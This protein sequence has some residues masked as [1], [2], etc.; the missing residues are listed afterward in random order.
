MLLGQLWVELEKRFGSPA[1]ISNSLLERLKIA[2]R[3]S[4]NQP[5]KLQQFADLCADVESQVEQLPSLACLNFAKEMQPVIKKL[6]KSICAK[7]EKEIGNFS[8]ANGGAYLP[9][10]APMALE[11]STT[12]SHAATRERKSDAGQGAIGTAV[13]LRLVNELK[14]A[15]VSLVYSQA[16]DAPANPTIKPNQQTTPRAM[17]SS[18]CSTSRTKGYERDRHRD[19]PSQLDELIVINA[20][21]SSLD[22]C[23]TLWLTL[24][25]HCTLR[26]LGTA[27]MFINH[28]HVHQPRTRSSTTYTFINH[29]HVH[30]ART[31]ASSTY[32]FINH[33]HVHQPRTCASTT[34]MFIN[35]VH[36]HQARTCSSSTYMFIKHVHVYQA[37]I[38]IPAKIDTV[39]LGGTINVLYVCNGCTNRR[40][41]FEGSL[42]VEDGV[43]HN[44]G[45]F[46]KNGSF[47]VKNYMT[48]GLLWYG[49]K[50]MRGEITEEEEGEELYHGTAKSMEGVL[51]EECYGQ[52]KE[53]GCDIICV[54]QDGDSSSKKSVHNVYGEEPPQRVYKCGGHVGRSHGNNLKDFAKQKAFTSTHIS[55]WKELFPEMENLKCHCTRHSKNCGCFSKQF[56]KNAR[57]NHFCCLQQ[58]DSPEEYA[59]RMRALS[60]HHVVDKHSWEGG[61]CGFHP[62]TVCSCGECKDE[63]ELKCEGI[64]YSTKNKLSCPFHLLAYQLE[65]ELRVADAKSVIH[66]EMGR[67]HSNQCEAHF[68]VLPHFRAKDQSLNR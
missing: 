57:V 16:R 67:G 38:L 40:L 10:E 61:N 25:V 28:V 44:R 66:P 46:S 2:A 30:Q 58:C 1:I 48:Q 4:E 36:V 65:C 49:N 63:F 60:Q 8:D 53:E 35:H 55:K 62:E 17:W 54:W 14:K 18:P 23:S 68:N 21:K 42:A 9:F 47:I 50:S 64:P 15:S 33:V 45:H 39:G 6:P 20:V 24:R 26:C 32:M 27:Y 59:R 52:A 34:H 11:K 22:D 5:E 13:Y 41:S 29:V 43:W 37:R 31:C 51:A 7:W 12:C 56:L 19:I 3:F